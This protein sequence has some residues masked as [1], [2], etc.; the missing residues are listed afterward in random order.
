MCLFFLFQDSY[1]RELKTISQELREIEVKL[2][3][4]NERKETLKKRKEFLTDALLLEK[5][6]KAGEDD[7]WERKG[8]SRLLSQEF[9]F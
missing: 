9:I 7:Q 1:E 2:R 5:S 8:I 4:L 3:S 6:K